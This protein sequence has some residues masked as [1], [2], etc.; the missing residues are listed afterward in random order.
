MHLKAIERAFQGR[1]S[2]YILVYRRVSADKSGRVEVIPPPVPPEYWWNK[3]KEKNAKL[4]LRRQQ[5]EERENAVRIR[6]H[7]PW[8]FLRAS[9]TQLGGL[10]SQQTGETFGNEPVLRLRSPG[11]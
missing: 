7:C 10:D 4:D 3:V 6:V 8:H 2:A 1:D 9:D 11:T 5:E